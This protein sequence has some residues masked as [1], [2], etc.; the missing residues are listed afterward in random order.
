M[1]ATS[2]PAATASCR[3]TE[4]STRREAGERPKETL[5]TPRSVETPGSS[6]FTRR[7]AAR[8]FAAAS[9][10]VASPDP[11]VKVRTSKRRSDG[12]SPYRCTAS[13]WISRAVATFSSTVIAIPFSWMVRA[14]TAAPYVFASRQTRSRFF[15]PS[16]RFTELTR[17][18]PGWIFSAASMQSGVVESIT[19]GI[20][21]DCAKSRT[22]AE[23]SAFS[24]LPAYAVHRSTA[25][26]PSS[27]CSRAI[28]SAP[29]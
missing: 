25:W 8:V 9:A 14:M 19:I 4:F 17:H 26:A 18:L 1:I 28:R 13:S 10:R 15:P 20:W 16:S 5:L 2:S 24:S 29:G 11:M 3:K 12:R 7:I 22:M 27:C 6:S 23:R 21:T